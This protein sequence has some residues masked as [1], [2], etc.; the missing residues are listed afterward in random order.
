MIYCRWLCRCVGGRHPYKYIICQ[1]VLCIVPFS[2]FQGFGTPGRSNHIKG[3]WRWRIFQ[4]WSSKHSVSYSGWLPFSTRRLVRHPLSRTTVLRNLPCDLSQKDFLHELNKL[5]VLASQS[6]TGVRTCWPFCHMHRTVTLPDVDTGWETSHHSWQRCLV[7]K[8]NWFVEKPPCCKKKTQGYWCNK[9]CHS[10]N[11][12][13]GKDMLKL[14]TCMFPL[15]SM[16]FDTHLEILDFFQWGLNF[17]IPSSR[18][19]DKLIS[20][21]YMLVSKTQPGYESWCTHWWPNFWQLN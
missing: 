12:K 17:T 8:H 11:W 6:I 9:K 19:E 5:G 15:L 10:E 2:F 1:R 14:I 3:S 20:L 18:V 7:T 4:S 13:S 16:L 21:P